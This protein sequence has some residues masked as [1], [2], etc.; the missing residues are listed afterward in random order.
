MK[1]EPY[2]RELACSG[3]TIVGIRFQQLINKNQR[4]QRGSAVRFSG[5]EPPYNGKELGLTSED[6]AFFR[7]F[8]LDFFCAALA[9]SI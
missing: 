5:I 4:H 7:Y 9:L 1:T 8:A 2:P 3:R 6:P